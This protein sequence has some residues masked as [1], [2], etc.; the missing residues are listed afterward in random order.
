MPKGMQGFQKGHPIY[1]TKGNFK[2][3]NHPK[4]EFKKGDTPWNKGKKFP[5][6]SGANHPSWRGG[7]NKTIDGYISIYKPNHPFKVNGN[8]VLEH[9]LVVEKQIGRYLHR[10]EVVHHIN[11]NITDNRSENLMVF[12]KDIYH[13]L[14][15]RWG[16][17][18]P[19]YI[20]FDGAKQNQME[21]PIDQ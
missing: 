10:W 19:K 3:G 14:F 15:H 2:K 7:K 6:T 1:T 11:K 13:R 5:E 20:V 9:R 18:N 17:Y 16:Y 12:N 8:Y 21:L 4:T